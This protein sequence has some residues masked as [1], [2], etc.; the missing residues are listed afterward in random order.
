MD[1]S[2]KTQIL[3]VAERLFA[4]QGFAATS[5]RALTAAAG[6]NL[7]AVNY[8]FGT[9][10]A[11]L[12]AVFERRLRPLNERR[13]ANMDRVLREAATA[14]TPP[15]LDQ[16]LEALFRPTF[17]LLAEP[18]GEACARLLARIHLEA[19]A[20]ALESLFLEQF[21]AVR[22][23]MLPAMH[24]ALPDLSEEDLAWHLHFAIG[25]LAHTMQGTVRL[26]WL[27]RGR[28]MAADRETT[29]ERLIAFC[30][31]GMR[32]ARPEGEGTKR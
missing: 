32:G 24:L 2:T 19:E 16:L 5:M 28:R 23:R 7:A 3:D 14:S 26:S 10:E 31:A 8:H 4:E 13:I 25:A 21:C 22:D 20:D 12:L 27:A 18:A 30:A 15:A 9:K 17:E 29:L 1:P 6:V 11:L